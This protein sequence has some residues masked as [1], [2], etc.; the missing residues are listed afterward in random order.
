MSNKTINEKEFEKLVKK[1]TERKNKSEGNLTIKEVLETLT[2][3]DLLDVYEEGDIESILLEKQ[4][5]K[6]KSSKIVTII[7]AIVLSPLLVFG[8]YK[9]KEIA[10]T[11]DNSTTTTINNYETITENLK[12]ENSGL[13]EELT[14]IKKKSQQQEERIQ[15]LTDEIVSIKRSE[16]ES[17]PTPSGIKPDTSVPPAEPGSVLKPGE[18]WSQGGMEMKVS[19][20]SFKPGCDKAFVQFDIS[21][22]NRS[23][24]DLETDIVGGNFYVTVD[25]KPYA[26]FSW[27]KNLAIINK[28]TTTSNSFYTSNLNYQNRYLMTSNV[29]SIPELKSEQKEEYYLVFWDN[30]YDLNQ[31]IVFHV[32]EAGNIKNAKWRLNPDN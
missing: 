31:E 16:P 24:A 20:V 17:T 8:G 32:K 29:L 30:I 5:R 19:E 11:F 23:G 12:Q 22:A 27:N 4:K 2:G 9:A 14:E 28:C 25:N 1:L 6:F 15:Q 26:N 7:S 18:T 10:L 21:I 3:S 13:E